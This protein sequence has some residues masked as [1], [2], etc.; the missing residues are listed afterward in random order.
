MFNFY[1]TL[2][3]FS[4]V[5]TFGDVVRADWRPHR[6]SRWRLD[7]ND[8]DNFRASCR[9]KCRGQ[10]SLAKSRRTMV[11]RHMLQRA[12][13]DPSIGGTSAD[14]DRQLDKVF[15][16]K[17][18]LLAEQG[19]SDIEPS[20]TGLFSRDIILSE[21][22]ADKIIAR[23]QGQQDPADTAPTVDENVATS[24]Q[25]AEDRS[26]SGERHWG[27]GRGRG[28][29]KRINR[30][31]RASA[32]S[33]DTFPKEKWPT[34]T[35]NYYTWSF[36]KDQKA[37][38]KAALDNIQS[39]TCL[40]F[41]E[42]YQKPMIEY[43]KTDA[44]TDEG[45]CGWA[46]MGYQGQANNPVHINFDSKVCAPTIRGV[47][48]HETMHVLGF[49]H[50]HQR[51]DRDKFI[52][53]DWSNVDP[54]SIDV[55]DKDDPFEVNPF[56]VPYDYESIM[57]Y[58]CFVGSKSSSKPAFAPLKNA[59]YYLSKIGNYDQPSV[60]DIALINKLY[61]TPA[62]CKDVNPY[63][64]FSCSECSTKFN[65]VCKKSCNQCTVSSG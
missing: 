20:D 39:K 33:V 41:V 17:K 54:Q 59:Q 65:S 57:H 5:A 62:D 8:I 45:T 1:A 12:R 48:A 50:E 36:S 16:A 9:G 3:L 47:I 21:E 4:T 60:N 7:A 28:W 51:H 29:S 26:R 2:F 24:A 63:C 46:Y 44:S 64:G 42:K 35:I 55:F 34:T 37:K 15:L 6:R 13:D 11:R 25:P 10:S 18:A 61:C 27:R 52:K 19:L 43:L 23:A 40:K 49:S 53:I 32:V 38:V 14:I 58:D 22:Q 30:K 31:K 56:C